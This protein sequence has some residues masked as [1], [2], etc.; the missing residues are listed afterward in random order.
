MPDRQQE[1]LKKCAVCYK[2]IE[3]RKEKKYWCKDSG[4]GLFKIYH[5]KFLAVK[6]SKKK[7]CRKV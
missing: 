7:F 1:T 6:F 4:L 3:K 5:T 2:E